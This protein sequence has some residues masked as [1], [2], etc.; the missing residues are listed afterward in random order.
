MPKAFSSGKAKPMP[1]DV[2]FRRTLYW[3][4]DVQVDSTGQASVSFYNNG[5]C[6]DIVVSAEGLTPDGSPLVLK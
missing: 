3:N 1:G 2:D 6:R 4:P 5:R